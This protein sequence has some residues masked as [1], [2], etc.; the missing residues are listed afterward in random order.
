MFWAV[1]VACPSPVANNCRKPTDASVSSVAGRP[2]ESASS[3]GTP[4][5][6]STTPFPM[7]ARFVGAA[8]WNSNV[9]PCARSADAA[10]GRFVLERYVSGPKTSRLQASAVSASGRMAFAT[11]QFATAPIAPRV[12]HSP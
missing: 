12:A 3:S 7:F 9:Q 8:T 4:A 11:I 1:T 10:S 2:T 5:S 6:V